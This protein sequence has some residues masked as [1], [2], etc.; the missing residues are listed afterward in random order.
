MDDHPTSIKCACGRAVDV[1]P[2]SPAAKDLRCPACGKPVSAAPRKEGSSTVRRSTNAAQELPPNSIPGYVFQKRIGQGGMGE[3]FL[4]KQ[5]SLDRLVAVKL[6]PPELAQDRAYVENF[7][8]EA[9]SAGKLNHENITGAVDVG[10]AGGRYYFVMEYVAGDTLW[11][12]VRKQGPFPEAKALD[13]VRQVARGLRH[14][15]HNGFVHRDIKPKNLLLTEDGVVKICDFGLA[16]A[17]KADADAGEEGLLHVTPAYASPEQCKADPSLDHRTDIYSLGVTLF[18]TLTGKRP[19]NGATSKDIMRKHLAEEPASPATLVPSISPGTCAL[20][21]RMLRKKPDERFKTY[22]ELLAAIEGIGAPAPALRVSNAPAAASSSSSSPKKKL[23]LAGAVAAAAAVLAVVIL[24]LAGGKPKETAPAVDPQVEAALRDA[25]ASQAAA[26]GRPAEYAGVKAKWQ[27]L[28]TRF[29]GTP[30]HPAF[31][32]GLRDFEARIGVEADRVAVELLAD[33]DASLRAGKPLEAIRSLRR[34]PPAFL[35]LEAGIR[36]GTKAFEAERALEAKAAAE[37]K[38]CE[39]HAIA[40]RFDEARGKLHQL[41]LAVTDRGDDGRETVL[42]AYARRIDDV[43]K[44]ID[45]EQALALKR[46][47]ENEPG[48]VVAK[49]AVPPPPPVPDAGVKTPDVAPP[50]PKVKPSPVPPHLLFLRD[51][52]QRGD[53]LM[54]AEALKGF[55]KGAAKHPLLKA[56]TLFLERAEADWKLDGPAGPAFEEYLASPALDFAASADGERHAAHFAFLATRIAAAGGKSVDVLQLFACAHAAEI[57][58]R[59]ER[60]E[61]G[62]ALQARFGKGAVS[63]LWG[64]SATVGRIEAAGLLAKPP[65][66]WIAKAGEAALAAPDLETRV[67]GLLFTLKEPLLDATLA[68]DKWKKFGAAAGDAAWQKTCDGVAERIRVPISCES[69]SSQGKYPCGAC[70]AAGIIACPACRGVGAVVDPSEG[71]KVTCVGC[72]GRKAALCTVCNGAK[73]HKCVACDTRKSRPLLPAGYFR[74]ILDL[75]ACEACAGMGTALP[76]TAWPCVSCAGYGRRVSEMPAEFAK[77]PAWTKSREGRTAWNALRWLSRHQTSDGHWSAHD[78]GASCREPGCLPSPGGVFDL[79]ST[80][81]TLLA[82]AGAGFDPMSEV[83]VGGTPAGETMRRALAWI[84]AR[85]DVEGHIPSAQ[86]GIK[87]VYEHLAALLALGT[88]LQTVPASGAYPER[89]RMALRDAVVRGVRWALTTQAKGG[90]WGYT[91]TAPSDSWVT[92]WGAHALLTARDAGIEIPKMNLGWIAQWYEAATDKTDFH[93][94]YSP[95]LM[96]RVNLPGNEA[97]L[98]HDTLSAYGGLI[99]MF[100]D[101][102]AQAT[103][104]AAEKNVER[105]LPSGDPLRRDYAY[106]YFGTLFLAHR[107][108]RKGTAWERWSNALSRELLALQETNDTCA[109]GSVPAVD[110]WSAHGGKVYAAAAAALALDV[111][112]GIRPPPL[113]GKK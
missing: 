111:V 20:V 90:G 110:R 16:R 42:P 81:L 4:A 45:A 15:H 70:G 31:F 96:G 107:D 51:P 77:L 69:C 64:P 36:I 44:R 98:H 2:G 91:V 54:R 72:K 55:A 103:I 68:A 87:P 12:V 35:K 1:P 22:D 79:G 85:Q 23:L 71:G 21:A 106:W 27:E 73:S 58:K 74:M 46:A 104:L 83:K 33:A 101:G 3:V 75:A 13:V 97:F 112:A 94:G 29:R 32:T 14:A 113:P 50:P 78:P 7:V 34:Y 92:S 18:E 86:V 9:R 100:V 99:R 19:F 102:K 24:L 47:K 108:Q 66:P 67:L 61:P 43:R 26:E 109:L 80:A 62:V 84:L 56:V 48:P 8:K 25:R 17:L 11:N 95:G 5:V 38:A 82:F 57:A 49:P 53:P 37:L 63:D 76:G 93:I 89:D 30:D 60:L 28:E 6:L 52:S 65:G 41:T 59:K 39:E 10:E 105:D 40:G 88:V